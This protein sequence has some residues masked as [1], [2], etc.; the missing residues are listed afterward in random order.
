MVLDRG[1]CVFVCTKNVDVES[2]RSGARSKEQGACMLERSLNAR[3]FLLTH[4]FSVPVGY[5]GLYVPVVLALLLP[6][7][8]LSDQPSRQNRST[9]RSMSIHDN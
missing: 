1:A 2:V 6:M 9:Y 5:T 8:S 7:A 4:Q 3:F